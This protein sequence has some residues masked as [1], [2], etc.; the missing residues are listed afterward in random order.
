MKHRHPHSL[1]HFSRNVSI[2]NHMFNIHWTAKSVQDKYQMD[3]CMHIGN[4][5]KH[6][7]VVCS[8][9][10][11]CL[12]MTMFRW[13]SYADHWTYTKCGWRMDARASHLICVWICFVVIFFTFE[14][15][16][17]FIL[18]NNSMQSCGEAFALSKILW[19]RW[20]ATVE[21]NNGRKRIIASQ[22]ARANC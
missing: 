8:C 12:T 4:N 20:D 10:R 13:I 2:R 3:A 22:S 7:Y 6:N 9:M 17:R 18:Y 19:F 5:N 14:S 16:S 21:L 15:S 11:W 1:W